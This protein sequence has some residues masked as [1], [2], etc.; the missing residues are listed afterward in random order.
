MPMN[1]D[2]IAASWRRYHSQVM[3]VVDAIMEDPKQAF[4]YDIQKVVQDES[5]IGERGG[6]PESERLCWTRGAAEKIIPKAFEWEILQTMGGQFHLT[7]KGYKP[8]RE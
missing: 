3:D 1:D 8:A 6:R 2:A 7:L 5:G 4:A